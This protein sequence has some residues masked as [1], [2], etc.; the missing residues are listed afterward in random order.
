[1][2]VFAGKGEIDK[3]G[4]GD[5]YLLKNAPVLNGRND[6]LGHLPRR[7]SE[8]FRESH[9][10]RRRQITEGPGLRDLY[11][12]L[13]Q[14]RRTHRFKGGFEYFDEVFFHNGICRK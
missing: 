13:R 6:L 12:D 9:G 2:Q 11:I 14:R 8:L 4:T 3:S 5:L 7:S 1:M 10:K